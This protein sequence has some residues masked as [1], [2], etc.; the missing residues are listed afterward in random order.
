MT[1][2]CSVVGVL[3]FATATFAQQSTVVLTGTQPASSG[4]STG[5]SATAPLVVNAVKGGN[6]SAT[7]GGNGDVTPTIP[8]SCPPPLLRLQLL[9]D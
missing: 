7:S 2:F 5:T 1:K 9:A 8:V 4:G 3:V 6:D